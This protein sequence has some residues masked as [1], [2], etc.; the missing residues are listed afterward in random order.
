MPGL[1]GPFVPVEAGRLNIGQDSENRMASPEKS[2][3]RSHRPPRSRGGT[4]GHGSRGGRW[5]KDGSTARRLGGRALPTL[6]GTAS[7]HPA[8]WTPASSPLPLARRRRCE[9]CSGEWECCV[10][11]V[12]RVAL[13]PRLARIGRRPSKRTGAGLVGTHVCTSPALLTGP[14]AGKSRP[15]RLRLTG[16]ARAGESSLCVA[17]PSANM[18][19][20][21]RVLGGSRCS[22]SGQRASERLEPTALQPALARAGVHGEDGAR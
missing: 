3:H 13:R 22:P 21:R 4:T 6:Y 5:R 15:H 8:Q 19:H 12:R 18:D 7:T 17:H 20:S 10:T 9:V 1:S 14:R 11:G 2:S 16:F